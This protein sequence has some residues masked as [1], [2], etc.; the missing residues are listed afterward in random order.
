MKTI[1][2][3]TDDQAGE[4]YCSDDCSLVYYCGV[5][6]SD[7]I[8]TTGCLLGMCDCDSMPSPDCPGSGEYVLFPVK[9]GMTFK[10]FVDLYKKIV[11]AA[12]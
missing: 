7:G 12:K 1:T 11:E 6:P 9:A 3:K 4:T 2:I 5:D 10:E 8:S